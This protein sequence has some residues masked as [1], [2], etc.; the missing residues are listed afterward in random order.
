MCVFILL[1]NIFVRSRSRGIKRARYPTGIIM[2]ASLIT[3]VIC[4]QTRT[5]IHTFVICA[6]RFSETP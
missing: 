1:Y 5:L 4:T 6:V 3:N 2:D